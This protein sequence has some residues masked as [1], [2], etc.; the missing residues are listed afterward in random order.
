M[1][2]FVFQ[3]LDAEPGVFENNLCPEI[4]HRKWYRIQNGTPFKRANQ[5]SYRPSNR[6]SLMKMPIFGGPYP[7]PQNFPGH[8]THSQISQFR[9][10]TTYQ[11]SKKIVR[12]VFEQFTT[13]NSSLINVRFFRLC[14]PITPEPVHVRGPDTGEKDAQ[15]QHLLNKKK[16]TRISQFFHP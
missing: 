11:N 2:F 8:G 15:S 16:S 10:P 12:P 5:Q 1:I 3:A 13:K 6:F 7:G 9:T 14:R 4:V